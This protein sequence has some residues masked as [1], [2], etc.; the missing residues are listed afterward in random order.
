VLSVVQFSFQQ[1]DKQLHG[2]RQS[3]V[4]AV[5]RMRKSPVQSGNDDETRN[6]SGAL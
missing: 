3:K 1:N 4:V 6:L 2:F 5:L